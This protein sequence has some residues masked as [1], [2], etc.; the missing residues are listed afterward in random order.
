M[1][2]ALKLIDE[3]G[4]ALS[5]R[6]RH[7]TRSHTRHGLEGAQP[8]EHETRPVRMVAEVAPPAVGCV[9]QRKQVIDGVPDMVL[10][11]WVGCQVVEISLGEHAV[12]DQSRCGFGYWK[13]CPEAAVRVPLG[14]A[15]IQ[16]TAFT[17]LVLTWA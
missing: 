17:I 7:S 6:G 10:V 12:R 8:G 15:S 3:E 14:G 11:A 4:A 13:G 1:D 9:L 16:A 5:D 2:R